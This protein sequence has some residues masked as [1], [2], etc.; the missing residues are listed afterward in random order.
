MELYVTTKK[1]LQNNVST[2]IGAEY[3]E[4]TLGEGVR[5]LLPPPWSDPQRVLPSSTHSLMKV[6]FGSPYTSSEN[7][8]QNALP[9][10]IL[11]CCCCEVVLRPHGM[12]SS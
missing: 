3:H 8:F 9:F 5:R 11:I 2:K 7:K 1:R 10:Y 6:V 12:S 4:P